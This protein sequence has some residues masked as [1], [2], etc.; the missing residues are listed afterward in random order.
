M[1]ATL[2]GGSCSGLA[3]FRHPNVRSSSSG[4]RRAI[5]VLNIEHILV[6]WK[7]ASNDAQFLKKLRGGTEGKP[8][9]VLSII[10]RMEALVNPGGE[11][12]SRG[13]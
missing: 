5:G 12:K 11:S 6:N 3:S 4:F 7:Q 8:M 9:I 10:E 2:P 1:T 13:K